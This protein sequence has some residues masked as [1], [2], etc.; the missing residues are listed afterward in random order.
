MKPQPHAWVPPHCPNPNCKYHNPLLPGWRFHHRG[1]FRSNCHPKPI[2][3]ALCL[4]CRRSFSAQTFASSYWLKKPQLLPQIATLTVA[5]CANRQIARTLACAPATVDSQ[6]ARLGRHCLLFQ[7]HHAPLASPHADIV[8]DGL[9]TF[10]FSQY[11]PFEH[12]IAVDRNSSFI[13]H[14]TDAPRRRCG[15]MTPFQKCRRAQLEARLGRADPKAVQQGIQ[16]VL[17]VA[18]QGAKQA[19]VRSDK[20]P[21]YRRAL[22]GLAC[23]IQHRRT[24]S[25]RRRDRHNE[26]FEINALDLMVRHSSANHK[27]ETIAFSKRRQA[28]AERLAVFVVWKNWVKRRWEKRC[29]QTPA[30]LRGLADRVLTMSEVLARRL[31]ASQIGLPPSWRQYYRRTVV[32]PVLGQGRRHVLKYA[33]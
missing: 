13:L 15:S 25:R 9:L 30:M 17:E 11:F 3:R 26:L 19:I 22:R 1:S 28:S 6:L 32:T 10:E 2:P 27:R 5:G 24:D 7:R 4:H 8:I 21:A 31:F 12:L 14:F 29:C 16:E 18:L 20:H 33:F 23:Q